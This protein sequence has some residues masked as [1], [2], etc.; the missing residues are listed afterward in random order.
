MEAQQ[1]R[2]QTIFKNYAFSKEGKC[3]YQSALT[4]PPN[5]RAAAVR[6]LPL[7]P[8]TKGLGR[9]LSEVSAF[10][11]FS[12]SFSLFFSFF[13]FFMIVLTGAVDGEQ[14]QTQTRFVVEGR[15]SLEAGTQYSFVSLRELERMP[16]AN[17]PAHLLR[18]L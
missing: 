14:T 18:P 7:R 3:G 13:F 2:Q 5:E 10:F 17:T 9:S 16:H 15:T 12:P 8:C 11:S 4:V 6:I 1:D